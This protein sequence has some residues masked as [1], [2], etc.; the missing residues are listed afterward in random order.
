LVARTSQKYLRDALERLQG[1]TDRGE[2]HDGQYNFLTYLL[3]KPELDMND[4]TI[5]TLSLFGDGLSTVGGSFE[6][7]NIVCLIVFVILCFDLIADLT[8]ITP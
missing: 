8:C 4:I 3:G 7:P 2:L 1:L 6:L 5:I